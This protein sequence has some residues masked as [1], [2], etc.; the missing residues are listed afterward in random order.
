MADH[1]QLDLLRQGVEAWNAWRDQHPEILIQLSGA[2][3]SGAIL[4]SADL[5]GADLSGADLSHATFSRVNSFGTYSSAHLDGANLSEANLFGAPLFGT[6]LCE[7]DLTRAI[8]FGAD[9]SGA[10]LSGAILTRANLI[11]ANLTRADLTRADLSGAR[12]GLT[13]FGDVDLRT[14]KG[15]ETII[16]KGPSTIG[17]DTLLRSEGDIPETFLRQAGLSD[18]FITYVHSLTQNPIEYYTCFISVR[19]VSPKHAQA[20]GWAGKEY[21]FYN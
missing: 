13:I 7:A 14:V 17:T 6:N 15:L 20:W 10:D 3:L 12:A 5:S 18:T 11:R 21:S 1:Q 19:L 4:I 2:D 8:L 9:L 16:H